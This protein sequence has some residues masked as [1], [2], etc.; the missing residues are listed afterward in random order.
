MLTKPLMC[1]FNQDT[2]Y[3]TQCPV[4][5][6]NLSE[7]QCDL[8]LLSWMHLSCIVHLLIP[9]FILHLPFN[10]NAIKAGTPGQDV[11]P[12]QCIT[13]T[14]AC[15]FKPFFIHFVGIWWHCLFIAWTNFP[16]P[17]LTAYSFDRSSQVY[18]TF[19]SNMLF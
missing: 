7:F 14:I 2:D 16:Q 8:Q 5:F 9:A 19:G 6:S 1:I 15:L 12:L 13:Y 4:T 3:T 10:S 11:R 17:C 18:K